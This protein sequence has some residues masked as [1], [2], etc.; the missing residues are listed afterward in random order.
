MI[1][2]MVASMPFTVFAEDPEYGNFNADGLGPAL[3]LNDGY[4]EKVGTLF[5]TVAPAT[6]IAVSCP[7]WGDEVGT[8]TASLYKWDTDYE[9][10]VKSE[11]VKR[12][13]IQDYP[14]NTF[15]GLKFDK[16]SP[17]AAGTYFLEFTDAKDSNGTGAGVRLSQ[18]WEGQAVFINGYYAPRTSLRMVVDYTTAVSG[19]VYGALP[20]FP[21]P[22]PAIEGSGTKPAGDYIMMTEDDNADALALSGHYVEGT[23][24]DDGT[25]L[26]T[27]DTTNNDPYYEIKF[28]MVGLNDLV[29]CEEYPVMAMSVRVKGKISNGGGEAFMYTSS[30]AGATV[31]YTGIVSYDY[32]TDDWQTIYVDAAMNAR[33]RENAENGDTWEGL[34]FDVLAG[35]GDGDPMTVEI[36]WIAFFESVDAA[37]NFDG[38]FEAKEEKPTA[39]P[40]DATEAPAEEPTTAPTEAPA[41]DPTTAPTEAPTEAPSEAPAKEEKEGCGSVITGGAALVAVMTGG[42]LLLGKKKRK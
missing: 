11:P 25:L 39:E 42:V 38:T 34:R 18:Q 9:T 3:K 12:E 4:T 28:A 32:S 7:S 26:L 36:R 29:S 35:R 1:A 27:V 13:T 2:A 6:R 5:T 33:F 24:T 17:L 40:S 37:V 10:T 21:K 19:N 22:R 31:G 41:A 20:D 8:V 14:T 23:V 30:V 15:V 16:G